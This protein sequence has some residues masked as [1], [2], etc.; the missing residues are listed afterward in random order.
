MK[1]VE[2]INVYLAAQPASAYAVEE[3]YNAVY[4]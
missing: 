3:R 4:P 1:A 2:V